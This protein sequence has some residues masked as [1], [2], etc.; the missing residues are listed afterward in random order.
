MKKNWLFGKNIIISGASGGLGFAIAKLLIE[1]YDCN[2]IGICR[3]EKKVLSARETL[4]DK[5]EKFSYVLFDVSDKENWKNFAKNLKDNGITPD[6]LINNAGFM[7]P[8]EVFEKVGEDEIDEI[9]DTNFKSVVYGAKYMLPLIR[10]SKTP[11]IIN[12]ASAAGRC[13]VVGET[14]YCATKYAVRGFTEAL[15][16]DYKKS[17]YIAGIYP[18]FIKT[19]ITDRLNLSEK[20]YG[21]ISKMMLPA[22]KAAK[23][24]VKRIRRKKKTIVIG[25]DGHFMSGCGRLFPRTTPSLIT[26]VLKISGLE[27]FDDVFNVEK[28][29]EKNK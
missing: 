20:N 5:K 15:H 29:K 6:I 8:F 18:G 1:K 3:N 2:V 4:K 7:L 10:E 11:A 27:L 9:I 17:I 26:S 16:Q 22:K 25:F 14:M 23:R 19:D 28:N 13:A 12:V 21:T 24:I